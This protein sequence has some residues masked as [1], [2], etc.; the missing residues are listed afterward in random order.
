M[1]TRTALIIV[2]IF[3]RG[4]AFF[5][6][7]PSSAAEKLFEVKVKGK[8]G[9]INEKGNIVVEPKYEY[10]ENFENK[11]VV[12]EKP[13]K[14][15]IIGSDQKQIGTEK[16]DGF[17]YGYCS[18]LRTF[19]KKDKWGFVD[20]AG[21]VVIPFEFDKLL[22]FTDGICL[23]TKE[24][25]KGFIDER[26]NFTSMDGYDDLF[27]N[28]AG[29]IRVGKKKKKG[30][31]IFGLYDSNQKKMVLDISYSEISFVYNGLVKLKK[32]GG[33]TGVGLMSLKT[34]TYLIEPKKD[35][36]IFGECLSSYYQCAGECNTDLFVL[37]DEKKREIVDKN[38]NV[39]LNAGEKYIGITY[40]SN[41]I[42]WA[43]VEKE[44][45]YLSGL[46]DFKGQPLSEFVYDEVKYFS[47]G[48]SAVRINDKWGFV[49][50]TGKLVIPCKFDCV[51]SFRNGLAKIISGGKSYDEFDERFPNVKMGYINRK[52]EIVWEPGN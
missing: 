46:I 49:D 31:F 51:F 16:Y 37:A 21:K 5:A 30:G 36:K 9:L 40:I 35:R 10:I 19:K 2:F 4:I 24:G 6:Q 42:C 22:F 17:Y 1:K 43:S 20:T 47:E 41:G 18:P 44:K 45:K 32:E 25:K 29:Y 8:W 38:N 15:F 13:G 39:I 3:F 14:Y 26:G 52:G 34:G 23:A 50:T 7:T 12:A 48:L 33:K 28:G 11:W 27:N